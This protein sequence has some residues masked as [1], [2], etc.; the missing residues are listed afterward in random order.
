MIRIRILDG[1][2]VVGGNKILVEGEEV[3]V[4]LDFG[5]NFASWG[6]YF[7]EFVTPRTGLI[8]KDLLNLGLLPKIDIY[9]SD[10]A[11][12][13]D[14]PKLSKN[15]IFAFLSHAHM[16]HMGFIGLL[17]EDIPILSTAETLALIIAINEIHSEEKSRLIVEKRT[18][19]SY[20]V[21]EDVL[22]KP[23]SNKESIKRTII[24]SGNNGISS[25]PLLEEV[26]KYFEELNIEDSFSAKFVDAQILPVYHSVIGS[27]SVYFNLNGVKIL[28]TGDLRDSPLPEEESLLLDIGENR[29]E[30]AKS[31]KRMIDYVKGKVDV[32]IVEGTRTRESHSVI[33]EATLFNN[34]YEEVKKN[35]GKLV[36]ADFPLRHLERFHT[37]LKVAKET[38][39]QFVVL[40]KDYLLLNTLAVINSD[41]NFKK[42]IGHIRVYHQGKGR[43]EGWEK[44][45]LEGEIFNN[46]PVEDI[47]IKP[48]KIE[49]SP[50]SYILNIGY[51]ELPNLLD[52]SRKILDGAVYIHSNSEAYTEEQN[53]DFTRLLN[54]LK[55][56]NIE[57]KGIREE[58]GKLVFDKMYHASGHM[59]PEGLEELIETIN[60][61]VVIP[62]HTESPEWFSS[63]WNK[64][65]RLDSDIILY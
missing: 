35:K 8:I 59:S 4:L 21:R 10:L 28:Y 1:Y 20:P 53:I 52:F 5:M 63:K 24:Y 16:D 14:L 54:W 56:F 30:L 49:E 45:F 9:R 62:V 15:I 29:L 34:V 32:L 25:L 23:K 37:F 55:H 39:R 50:G 27:A 64:K 46:P 3:S 57:P 13:I 44:R 43:W 11:N 18:P 65:V 33:T 6:E 60:P 40:A 61:N 26:D 51:Y 38:D 17:N 2:R 12:N 19:G 36:I 48:S 42:Y 47:L 58:S 31:T 22:V 7:E 41:W